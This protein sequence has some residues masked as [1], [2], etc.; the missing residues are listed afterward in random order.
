[1]GVVASGTLLMGAGGLAPEAGASCVSVSGINLG[2]G[3][4]S[5]PFSMAVALGPGAKARAARPFTFRWEV[6]V[7]QFRVSESGV[8]ILPPQG[9]RQLGDAVRHAVAS[10]IPSPVRRQAG[11]N[12]SPGQQ[13][14]AGV[15][16]SADESAADKK[17]AAE[18]K[19]ST[20]RD[21]RDKA[22]AAEAAVT[23]EIAKAER[24][25]QLGSVHDA[26]KV[27][28]YDVSL[29]RANA[30]SI[31]DAAQREYD[32]LTTPQASTRVNESRRE[33]GHEK[34]PSS[35]PGVARGDESVPHTASATTDPPSPVSA[36]ARDRERPTDVPRA[37]PTAGHGLDLARD[38]RMRNGSSAETDDVPTVD[39]PGGRKADRD[40]LAAARRHAG[41]T[42]VDRESGSGS[43]L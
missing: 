7:G 30:E 38:T 5:A 26:L 3:C 31:Y 18:K 23:E 24:E 14:Q 19:L 35:S 40:G 32:A 16:A 36:D 39:V 1:M 28:R 6:I 12:G 13:K 43:G 25:G 11:V 9:L 34:A 27:K 21:A 33:R 29:I 8:Q 42:A 4:S 41:V 10:V 37:E 17:A 15:K 2:S 22:R 20:L